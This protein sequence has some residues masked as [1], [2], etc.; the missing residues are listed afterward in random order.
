MNIVQIHNHYRYNGGENVN[1]KKICK[2]LKSHNHNVL[3]L[4]RQSSNIANSIGKIRAF[5]SGINSLD[6]NNDMRHIINFK[7][8]DIV[9]VHNLYPLIS[10]SVLYEC[11][12]NNIP[13]VMRCPNYRL[14]CPTG[15]HLRNNKI[16]ELCCGGKE[17]WCI[18]KNCR[19][20]IFESL[21]YAIRN[22]IARKRR[23]FL[24]SITYYLPPTN[25]VKNRLIDAGYPKDRIIVLP[26][27]VS[28]PDSFSIPPIGEYIAYV[29]RIS[30]EKG[31]ETLIKAAE[32]T[33][34]DLKIAG[35]YSSLP[36]ILKHKSD[37]INF[38]GHLTK[39]QLEEFYKNARFLVV[40]SNW[41]EPFGL[42]IA[43]AMGLGLPVIGSKIGGISE[44]IENG[45]TGFLF[46]PGNHNDLAKKIKILWN[47]PD[48][49]RK[50]GAK[51]RKKA[52]Q[53]Y[54][55]STYYHSLIKIYEKAIK[56]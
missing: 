8:P 6:A 10:P 18:L 12:Q 28:L 9:H 30:P 39:N 20:D 55:E 14:V 17:I 33:D 40:P 3:T 7:S 1:F 43:E 44:I 47:N 49:C 26:N 42:V 54:S 34:L 38:V 19:N 4:E 24:K 50:M 51:G 53:E 11:K 48:L 16:C 23:I 15:V 29:G 21:S 35:D 31:I 52:T 5:L 45:L 56:K 2:L 25:F 22:F 27:M 46:E 37:K 41:Y 13:V 36:G 32:R